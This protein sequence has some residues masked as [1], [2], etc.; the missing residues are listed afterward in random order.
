[1]QRVILLGLLLLPSG[2][3]GAAQVRTLTLD[4]QATEIRF[5]LD[6]TLH[7]VRGTARLVRG[8]VRFQALPGPARGEVVIDARSAE[9]GNAARDAKMHEDVLRSQEHPL[10]VLT[11]E[12]L[13]G[14]LRGEGPS[15]LT[16]HGTLRLAGQDHR[17]E[18]PV[19]VEFDGERARARTRFA[20]PYVAWGL[21]DP[22]GFFLRVGKEVTVSVETSGKL[23]EGP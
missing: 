14:Q 5:T 3:S 22:S 18:L 17:I 1:M 23:T 4:P 13:E 6:A 12:R 2:V 10:M 7:T 16:L 20:I 8:T 9:T 21:K 19:E 15:A 11:P